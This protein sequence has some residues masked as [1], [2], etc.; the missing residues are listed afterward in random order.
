MKVKSDTAQSLSK[1][2]YRSTKVLLRQRREQVFILRSKGCSAREIYLKLQQQFSVISL[3]SV[4]DDIEYTNRHKEAFEI[5]LYYPD[6]SKHYEEQQKQIDQMIRSAWMDYHS[7]KETGEGDSK[8]AKLMYLAELAMAK[9]NLGFLE[10]FNSHLIKSGRRSGLD[11]NVN[12]DRLKK[13]LDG[14]STE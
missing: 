2:K 1:D 12:L 10:P 6:I 9:A 11:L 13:V 8:C 4:Y 14:Y 5:L 3:N 7:A